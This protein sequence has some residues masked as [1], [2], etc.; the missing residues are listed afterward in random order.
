MKQQHASAIT[1]QIAVRY[2]EGVDHVWESWEPALESCER[3]FTAAGAWRTMLDGDDLATRLRRAQYRAHA[4]AEVASG[5]VPPPSVLEAHGYLLSS[6]GACRDA[7]GVLAVR[8]DLE[9]LDAEDA[10]IGLHAVTTTRD[11]FRG[12]R[13]TTALVHAWVAEDQV[14]P[15]WQHD[16]VRPSRT[17][18]YVLWLLVGT[19]LVLFGA[20]LAQALL[21]T[22]SA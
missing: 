9:E 7:L 6:L 4:A 22:G 20:L 8:A 12:A 17:W 14:D 5:L 3:A 15:A 11:A 21:G 2:A 16:P 1:D 10:E 19:C 18:P 13:S